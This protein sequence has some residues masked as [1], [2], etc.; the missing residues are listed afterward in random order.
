[1]KTDPFQSCDHC[2]VFQI[3][4]YIEC[5]PFTASSFKIWN[6]SPGIPSPPLALFLVMLPK[7]HLTSHFRKSGS[8]W[9]HTIMVIRVIKISFVQFFCYSCHLFLISSASVRS[10][11]FLSFIVPI[12][13]WNTPLVSNFFEE[14]SSFPFCFCLFLC[15]DH[16]RRLSNFSLLFIGTLHSDG[17]IFPFLLCLSC[18][19]SAICKSSSGNHFAFLNFFFSWVVLIMASC[20]MLWTSL[21]SSSGSLSIRSNPLNLFVTSTV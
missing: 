15:I 19:V 10:I 9:V 18:L 21:H 5:S 2:W 8:T 20:T 17:F 7:T 3:G 16:L 14:I 13:A 6:N 4:W 1:M 11:P 12:F